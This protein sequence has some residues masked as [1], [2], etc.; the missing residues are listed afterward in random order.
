[1][2]NTKS[3]NYDLFGSVFEKCLL[4]CS[5]ESL[6]GV[7]DENGTWTRTGIGRMHRRPGIEWRQNHLSQITT[8][9]HT[10]PNYSAIRLA[11]TYD[12]LI[13]DLH[14]KAVAIY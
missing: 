12:V 2:V 10:S 7:E 1:M 14:D 13:S 8:L 3:Y 6:D 5:L 11:N 4:F 9:L